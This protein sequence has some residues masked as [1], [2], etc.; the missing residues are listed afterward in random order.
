MLHV[1][2]RLFKP[3]N[4]KNNRYIKSHSLYKGKGS[5]RLVRFSEPI[6]EMY[7]SFAIFAHDA[8]AGTIEKQ[9]VISNQLQIY[10]N[11]NPEP[12]SKS[13][14]PVLGTGRTWWNS[15]DPAFSN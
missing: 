15:Y 14:W 11:Y 1:A 13:V 9:G 3:R 6:S 8:L 5:F 2:Y 7:D 10:G 12:K 4:F